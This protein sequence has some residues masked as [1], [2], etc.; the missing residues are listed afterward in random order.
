MNFL[1]Y[2]FQLNEVDQ[3]LSKYKG[4]VY[5]TFVVNLYKLFS[6]TKLRKVEIQG[7]DS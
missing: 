2:F 1:R 3:S 6:A 5:Y 4:N 7:F